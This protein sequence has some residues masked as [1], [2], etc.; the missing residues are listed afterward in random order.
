[1]TPLTGASDGGPS[2]VLEELKRTNPDIVAAV[3]ATTDGFAVHSS[4]SADVDADTVAAVAADLAF[5][6]TRLAGE[7]GQG[8]LREVLARAEGGYLLACVVG[9]DMV[10]AVV[11]KADVSIG[12]LLISIRKAAARLAEQA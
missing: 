4:V 1:V 7:L 2:A 8:D 3:L 9:P 12:L 10:L 5:R 11:A 6:A